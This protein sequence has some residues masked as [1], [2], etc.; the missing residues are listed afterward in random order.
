M[1]EFCSKYYRAETYFC[2]LSRNR[3]I[4]KD[5]F[6]DVVK[7]LGYDANRYD[8]EKDVFITVKIPEYEYDFIKKT[9]KIK[10]ITSSQYVSAIIDDEIKRCRHNFSELEI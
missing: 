6:H 4:R 10:N 8:I 5:I 9:I 3:K 2:N 1:R 7:I